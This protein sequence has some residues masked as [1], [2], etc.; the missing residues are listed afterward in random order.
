MPPLSDCNP[1][2]NSHLPGTT[3]ALYVKI[4]SQTHSQFPL[5][6]GWIFHAGLSKA[7][8]RSVIDKPS[9]A[10][11]KGTAPP[12]LVVS[13]AGASAG[14]DGTIYLP[15]WRTESVLSSI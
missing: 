5:E 14:Q 2:K 7:A 13:K 1:W 6:P 11:N 10:I 9:A 8:S 15:A 4:Y 3:S 12:P